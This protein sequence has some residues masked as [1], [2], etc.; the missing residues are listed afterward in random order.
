MKTWRVLWKLLRYS[1]G[2]Y[3]LSILIQLPRRLI[4]LAPA[5]IVSQIFDRLTPG[6]QLD[7]NFW[8]L[9]ALFIG[10]GVG[11][12]TLLAAS[13]YLELL[14]QYNS[15]TLLR[16]NLFTHILKQPGAVVL[17]YA[18]G[19]LINRLQED[20]RNIAF[21]MTMFVFVF[22]IGVQMLIALIIM[23]SVNLVITLVAVLPLFIG[24]VIVNL[25][26]RRIQQ[27]R[28]VYRQTTGKVSAFLGE[29][30]GAVQAIQI[31]T[32]EDA[33]IEQ[34]TRLNVDRR[35]AALRESLFEKVWL[36]FFD[37]GAANLGTALVVLLAGRALQAGTFSVGDFVLFTGYLTTLTDFISLVSGEIT[38]YKQIQVAHEQR[39]LPLLSGAP[40]DELTKY[41]PIYQRGPLPTIPPLEK[42][43]DD[44][45][46]S[47]E[48]HNLT[49][50]YPESHRGI[51]GVNF[52]LQRGNLVV[53][54]GR[55]GAGKTTLLRT[56]LGL[57]PKEDGTICWNNV[58]VD[59]PATFFV[60][61]HCAYTPQ[62]PTLF[63]DSL[64]TNI[65]LGLPVEEEQAHAALYQAVMERDLTSFEQ[66]LDTL[67]G[68]QGVRL[69]GGQVLRTAAARMFLH[70]ADLL[71][72]DD[73]SSALDIETEQTLWQRLF[74]PRAPS[75][76]E[77]TK[78]AEQ[79]PTC[80]VVSHR[81]FLLQLADHII[82][83]KAGKVEAEGT[84]N[85]LL[86]ESEEMRSLW[87]GYQAEEKEATHVIDSL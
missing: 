26:G 32:S 76:H 87:A 80:L 63:S 25:A 38:R 67:V 77:D 47:L 16:K 56:L 36:G 64:F 79:K 52:R 14:P 53:I 50:R 27:Y 19:D 17:P 33:I 20:P 81:P 15:A 34:L 46:E 29:T 75:Q 8:G 13:I 21:A 84:L 11:R 22:G 54:T 37:M 30:F 7:W 69:S 4:I 59:D 2:T 83:L 3:L 6:A 45:L 49:Y 86:A 48:V 62:A 23:A 40:E 51:I 65:S 44:R 42:I 18:S 82:V 85:Q 12:I 31:S 61:P 78:G 57:L 43:N 73:L 58:Q 39:L 24:G 74:G 71:V 1:P 55:V 70:Q 68:P 10:V 41:G 5:L 72:F 35:R 9:I 28:N 66:G 60:P